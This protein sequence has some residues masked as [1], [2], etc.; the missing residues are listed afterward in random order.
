MGE[1]VNTQYTHVFTSIEYS[2]GHFVH[3][4]NLIKVYFNKSI[5]YKMLMALLVSKKK[6]WTLELWSVFYIFYT[7]CIYMYLY[8]V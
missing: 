6:K 5:N 7:I 8:N 3:L 2:A 4:V 1:L